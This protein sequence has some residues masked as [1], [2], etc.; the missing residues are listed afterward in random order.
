M[1]FKISIGLKS[2]MEKKYFSEIPDLKDV[3]SEF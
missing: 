3:T 2:V 1:L